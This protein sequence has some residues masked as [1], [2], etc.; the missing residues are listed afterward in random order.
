MI[1]PPEYT[2]LESYLDNDMLWLEDSL[3]WDE[4]FDLILSDFNVYS[5]LFTSFFYN[6][7]FFLDSLIKL[8][9]LDIMLIT[10]S[11]KQFYVKELFT[12]FIWDLL[13]LI[14][15][16]FLILQFLFYTDYQ[17]YLIL[18]LH[19]SPELI[20]AL[21]DYINIYWIQSTLNYST[22]AVF[23][24]FNDSVNSSISEFMEYFSL[25]FF[26]FFNNNYFC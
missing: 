2:W 10:E 25:I 16:K 23:D 22:A 1:L 12:V 14:Y 20:L 5:F 19:Y 4:V 6:S 11:T 24:L 9:V 13:T 17:D 21:N 26:F 8:S 7:H 18:L 15:N 3:N